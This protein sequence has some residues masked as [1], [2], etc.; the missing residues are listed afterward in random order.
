M[1]VQCLHIVHS[2]YAKIDWNWMVWSRTED[3]CVHLPLRHFSSCDRWVL[4][5]MIVTNHWR[6]PDHCTTIGRF[7]SSTSL[8]TEIKYRL[9]WYYWY[10]R[11]GSKPRLFQ[12]SNANGINER[13][14]N[15]S[16]SMQIEW[17]KFKHLPFQVRWRWLVVELN[18]MFCEVRVQGFCVINAYELERHH[19]FYSMVLLPN[20]SPINIKKTIVWSSTLV[21]CFKCTHTHTQKLFSYLNIFAGRYFFGFRTS[22]LFTWTT[23]EFCWIDSHT[24]LT[25]HIFMV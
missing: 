2:Y 12:W 6:S 19:Q 20:P 3:C 17:M 16:T 8:M 21:A 4:E 10:C 18:A 14:K 23:T 22:K 13:K 24:A 5:P 11:Y 9:I 25:L 15:Q 1:N 7:D